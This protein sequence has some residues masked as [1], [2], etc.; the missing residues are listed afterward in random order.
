MN[1]K[2]L[3]KTLII[4]SVS[5]LLTGWYFNHYIWSII[6][7]LPFHYS[8]GALSNEI[9]LSFCISMICLYILIGYLGIKLYYGETE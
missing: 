8:Y 3:G 5:L 2:T 1:K 9:Y 4:V 7:I 6:L